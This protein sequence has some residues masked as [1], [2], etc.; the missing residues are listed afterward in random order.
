MSAQKKAAYFKAAFWYIW[1][2]TNYLGALAPGLASNI[3][4]V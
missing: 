2:A 4:C 1:V 3:C